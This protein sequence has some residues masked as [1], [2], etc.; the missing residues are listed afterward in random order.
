M[1]SKW[2]PSLALLGILFL[3]GCGGDDSSSVLDYSGTWR[4]T[5]SHG[6]TVSF[7]VDGHAVKSFQI[8]DDQANVQITKPVAV[9]GDSFSAE[10]SAGVSSPGSPAVSL[11]CTF[12]SETH[13]FGDYSIQQPPDTWSGTFEASRQ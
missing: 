11:H 7:I 5:T 6:G 1:K 10:N 9:K 12:E 3:A 13:G 8:V 4:G 2:P